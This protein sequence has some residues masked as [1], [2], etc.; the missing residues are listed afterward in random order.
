MITKGS[1]GTDLLV[2]IERII[3]A[4]GQANTINSSSATGGTS[5]TVNLAANSLLVNNVPGI[6][7]LSFTVENFVNVIS[8]LNDDSITGNSGNNFLSGSGGG[9]DTLDGGA[10]NDTLNGGSGSGTD[11]DSLIGGEGNDDLFGSFGNDTLNGEEGDDE[12]FGAADN[13]IFSGAFGNDSLNG[14]DGNDRL[15]GGDGNDT[16]TGGFNADIFDFT[17]VFLSPPIGIDTITDFNSLEG[18]R[19]QISALG[20]TPTLNR[21]TFDSTSGALFFDRTQFAS[22]QLGSDFVINRDLI[23]AIA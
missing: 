4:T 5:L 6:G 15:N 19:V 10:G 1:L 2:R 18:D 13:D 7:T 21:F 17:F 14:E 12:L 22:L 16:L 8:T 9:N 23:I 11:L 20:R 3:G